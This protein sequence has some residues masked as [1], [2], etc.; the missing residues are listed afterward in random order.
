MKRRPRNPTY[1]TANARGRN[2]TTPRSLHSSP[3]KASPPPPRGSGKEM[4]PHKTPTR[5]DYNHRR[6]TPGDGVAPKSPVGPVPLEWAR[7]PPLTFLWRISLASCTP[8]SSSNGSVTGGVV[9][10]PNLGLPKARATWPI[11]PMRKPIACRS[12]SWSLAENRDAMTAG[13]PPGPSAG[14]SRAPS[15]RGARE[16]KLGKCLGILS[17]VSPRSTHNSTGADL[18]SPAGFWARD[19]G[20]VKSSQQLAECNA[21]QC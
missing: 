19:G 20:G 2:T 21:I 9:M 7:G 14:R 15:A 12:S 18:S 11:R 5:Y 8:E 3:A 16:T 13:I 10:E 17:F 1:A 4:C 6:Q